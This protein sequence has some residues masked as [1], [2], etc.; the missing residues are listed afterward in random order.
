[1][2][3]LA[4]SLVAV[5]ALALSLIVRRVLS[6]NTAPPGCVI[7]ASYSTM[8]DATEAKTFL[9][10]YGVHSEFDDYRAQTFGQAQRGSVHLLVRS[11]DG[12][13]AE[14]AFKAR[15]NGRSATSQ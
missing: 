15:M 5:V 8:R 12:P 4:I 6:L 2:H 3:P 1:M 14:A 13:R 7:I 11:A 10:A 9:S